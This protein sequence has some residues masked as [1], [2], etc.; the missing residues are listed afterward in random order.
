MS[1]NGTQHVGEFGAEQPGTNI[2]YPMN[3]QHVYHH[4][5]TAGPRINSKVEKNWKG[6]NYEVTVTCARDVAEAMSLLREAM[7]S[8][9]N[10]YGVAPSI[11]C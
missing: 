3:S 9:A 6:F 5:D 11:Q 7:E 4:S 10:Q 8:L 1:M 2:I